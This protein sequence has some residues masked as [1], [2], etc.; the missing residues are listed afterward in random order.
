MKTISVAVKLTFT[1][2][3]GEPDSER[4]EL[5]GQMVNSDEL[6]FSVDIPKDKILLTNLKGDVFAAECKAVEVLDVRDD[7]ENETDKNG[8][9][10]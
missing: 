5:F 3:V 2:A 1:V 4:E 9:L 7:E 10:R 8:Q 6:L